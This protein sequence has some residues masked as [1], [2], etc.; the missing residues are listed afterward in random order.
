MTLLT[1]VPEIPT[2]QPSGC[3]TSALARYVGYGRMGWSH[4]VHPQ[5]ARKVGQYL[6]QVEV[7]E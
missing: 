1:A 7:K 5:P 2:G 6:V 4:V 3:L